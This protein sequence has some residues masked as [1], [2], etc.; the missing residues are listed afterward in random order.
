MVSESIHNIE[1][2]TLFD[3]Y[4]K[5]S[6]YHVLSKLVSSLNLSF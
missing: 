5:P 6:L 3:M 2:K 1:S 4:S